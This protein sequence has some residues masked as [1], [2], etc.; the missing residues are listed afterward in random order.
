MSQVRDGTYA[1]IFPGAAARR[2][3]GE[4][5]NPL[6]QAITQALEW[7][8]RE[9]QPEGF[10]VGMIESNCCMEAQWILAMHFFPLQAL[11]RA[12]RHLRD[13]SSSPANFQGAPA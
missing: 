11:G 9:Q 13:R 2:A 1:A 6:D 7:L 4:T 5:R 8:V 12:R 3:A 10:R